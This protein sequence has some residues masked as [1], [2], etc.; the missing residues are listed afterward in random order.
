VNALTKIENT[1]L[2]TMTEAELCNVLQ[3]SL[4]PGASLDS[5]K[6]VLGYCKASSLDPMRKPVH[7]VPMWDGKTKQM[8]DVV[9]PGVGLYRTDASRTGEHVGTDKPVYGP[10]VEYELSGVKIC[11]P[12]WCAVT[13][14]RLKNGIKC[15]Y[16][17]EEYWIENYATAGKDTT[18]PN[19]MWKKRARGQLA[20]C[21]EAQALRKAFP[22]VGSQPTADEME[23]K[24]I[25]MG[26]AEVV[27]PPP[28]PPPS[29]PELEPWPDDKLNLREQKIREW[30]AIGKTVDEIVAFLGTKGAISP[31]QR[32]RIGKWMAEAAAP[33]MTYAQVADALTKA[34]DSDALAAA[35]DLINTIA[36][37][38]QRAELSAIFDRRQGELA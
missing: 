31:E 8:R 37:E 9:M 21:A 11:V 26:M 14:Y 34:V 4:Y 7:I 33:A 19:S 36:D 22:E 10:M 27:T 5:I 16:T 17:A 13:V 2:S 6:M 30:A 28:P 20:K 35:A 23:G 1:A 32:A 24:S 18:A 3:T 25:D 15:A 29:P 38:G 12:E